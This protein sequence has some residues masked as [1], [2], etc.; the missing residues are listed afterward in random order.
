MRRRAGVGLI[1][2]SRRLV[3]S[4]ALAG[5]NWRWEMSV[6]RAIDK[7]IDSLS[8]IAFGLFGAAAICMVVIGFMN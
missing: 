8:V 6:I 3:Y 2:R 7:G 4:P 5:I 1:V